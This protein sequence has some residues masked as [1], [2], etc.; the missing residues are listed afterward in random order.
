MGAP[1]QLYAIADLYNEF[2]NGSNVNVGGVAF[3]SRDQR[4]WAELGVGGTYQWNKGRYG[5]YGNLSLAGATNN[6]SDNHSVG[7]MIGFRV[8]W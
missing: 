8:Q 7:G 5:M 3:R 2:M 6:M 1:S 4:L